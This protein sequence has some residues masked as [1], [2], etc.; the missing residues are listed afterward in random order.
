MRLTVQT[1]AMHSARLSFTALYVTMYPFHS[2]HGTLAIGG[3]GNKYMTI[4][5]PS[6]QLPPCFK[7]VPYFIAHIPGPTDKIQQ[8]KLNTN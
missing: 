7:N 8:R 1:E 3:H 6:C 5:A 2:A 4:D